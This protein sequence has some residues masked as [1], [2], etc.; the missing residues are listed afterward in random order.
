MLNYYFDLALR[1]LRHSKVLT[2]LMVLAI[3]LGVGASMTMLTVVHVM[4]GDPLPGRSAQLYR[5][6][7]DPLPI[8]FKQ[9]TDGPDPSNNL[10]W[11]DA[12]ALLHA[13]RAE[14][15][16]AMAGG[17]LLVRPD[18]SSIGPFYV[19][20]RYCTSDL[21][22]MFGLTLLQGQAWSPADDD[23]RS[24]VV[25]LS[26]TLNRMLF[27]TEPSI[28]QTV[29]LAG[30]DFRVVGVTAH[31]N[32][33][34][35]F[36]VDSDAK[37]Y[38]DTDLFFLPLT[39]AVDLNLTINGNFANW[40][41]DASHTKTDANTSWLQFWVQLNGDK[42]TTAY[43]EFL[44]DYS[45]Q[46][47]ALGRFTR[48]PSNA[49]LYSMMEWLAH[50]HL[51]PSEVRLQLLL[52][53]GFLIVCITNIIALLLAKFLRRSGEMSIRRALG[54]KRRDI[55]LQLGIES[56]VIGLAGGM[57]G[58]GIAQIGLWGVR[59]RPDDYAKLAQMDTSMLLYTLGLAVLASMLAGLLPAWRACNIQPALQLK[60]Q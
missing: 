54:A 45:A 50:M 60:I 42:Q 58:L 33:R 59:H 51:V 55:F 38:G 9:S 16:A 28:G 31:W 40:G 29:N 26:E 24:R 8:D 23:A 43:K 22:S 7:I 36:Y 57:L 3:G 25:I 4:S 32:P 44:N 53:F 49:K 48:P 17:E 52:A 39:T 35:M 34:P 1:S 18:Q 20:G 13:K 11:P 46:Q 47:R 12:M 5:P 14:K 15:Q 30:H 41:S 56:A 2:V 37:I 10:T 6:H 19:S 27:G 21:F